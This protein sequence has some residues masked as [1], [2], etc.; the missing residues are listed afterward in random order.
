ML[1]TQVRDIR[2]PG[3]N[4]GSRHTQ[5]HANISRSVSKTAFNYQFLDGLNQVFGNGLTFLFSCYME[6]IQSHKST[7]WWL[8]SKLSSAFIWLCHITGGSPVL[9]SRI[10]WR[11]FAT[12]NCDILFRDAWFRCPQRFSTFSFLIALYM[13][14][15]SPGWSLGRTAHFTRLHS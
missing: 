9:L 13:I 1:P 12:F 5:R 8:C 14:P 15:V 4:Y 2:G 6:G 11:A 3:T 7:K 10:C